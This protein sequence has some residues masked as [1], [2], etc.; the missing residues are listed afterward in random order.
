MTLPVNDPAEHEAGGHPDIRAYAEAVAAELG[1]GDAGGRDAPT[2]PAQ[3]V[4]AVAEINLPLIRGKVPLTVNQRL[5]EPEMARRTAVLVDTVTAGA[6]R[7][8]LGRHTH[9]NVR[10]HFATGDHR[11]RD[12]INLAATLTP[13]LDGLVRAGVI[14]D[15]APQH[16]TRWS[17]NV[18][19]TPGARRLWLEIT[20]TPDGPPTLDR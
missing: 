16:V 17:A 19:A 9:I 2:D 10:L 7:L 18:H 3:P 13:C 20:P 6:A 12:R 4:P 11:G 15:T 14:P 5:P 1:H 8:G